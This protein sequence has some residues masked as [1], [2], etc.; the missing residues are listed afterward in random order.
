MFK[1]V[2]CLLGA[3]HCRGSHIESSMLVA[4]DMELMMQQLSLMY[5]GC[6]LGDG[7]I[8][9]ESVFPLSGARKAMV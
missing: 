7:Y 2:F 9:Q 5:A 3:L 4:S 1:Y 8:M 6:R